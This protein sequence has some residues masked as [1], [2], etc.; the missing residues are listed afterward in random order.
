MHVLCKPGASKAMAEP[1]QSGTVEP[2]LL[3]WI[4]P[5]NLSLVASR[6]RDPVPSPQAKCTQSSLSAQVTLVGR[7]GPQ[8]TL[9]TCPPCIAQCVD[10]SSARDNRVQLWASS[11]CVSNY[12]T[13]WLC[14]VGSL[15]LWNRGVSEHL[16]SAFISGAVSL[17]V[18]QPDSFGLLGDLHPSFLSRLHGDSSGLPERDCTNDRQ[19]LGKRN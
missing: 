1:K 2:R 15:F 5:P 18:G 8:S 3:A 4:S 19:T 16:Y 11:S 12:G 7:P 17:S 14:V 9:A 13:R 10:R 6:G